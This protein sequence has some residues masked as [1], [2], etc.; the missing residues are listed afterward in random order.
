M[1]VTDEQ[2]APSAGARARLL[3]PEMRDRIAGARA[4]GE[5]TDDATDAEIKAYLHSTGVAC[6]VAQAR[7]LQQTLHPVAVVEESAPATLGQRLSTARRAAGLSRRDL[8][9]TVGVSESYLSYLE[10][11]RRDPS[12]STLAAIAVALGKES[13]WLLRGADSQATRRIA[14]LLTFV[15]YAIDRGDIPEAEQFLGQL[16]EEDLGRPL[17]RNERDQ[18]LVQ[19]ALRLRIQGKY[20]EMRECLAPMFRRCLSGDSD[21]SV[22]TVGLLY[23]NALMC[24]SEES[25]RLLADAVLV[26]QQAMAISERTE[27]WWRVAATVVGCQMDLGQVSLAVVQGESWLRE[28]RES[29]SADKFPSAEAALLWNLGNADEMVGRLDAALAKTERALTLQDPQEYPLDDARLKIQY[30]HHL[31]LARPH[32]VAEAIS[33]LEDCRSVVEKICVPEDLFEWTRERARAEM[34][35]GRIAQ[36]ENLLIPIL[37]RAGRE[38]VRLT[39]EMWLLLGDMRAWGGNPE[40][41]Y[42]AYSAATQMLQEMRPSRVTARLWR[43][44]GDRLARLGRDPLEVAGTYARALDDDDL[45]ARPG[46]PPQRTETMA[47]R[48]RLVDGT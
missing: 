5:L 10:S 7:S 15:R 44:T 40:P 39:V 19:Q 30:A 32:R 35:A 16:L 14:D 38:P 28:L 33:V 46:L 3:M 8:S 47:G 26:G 42:A 36:A 13:E 43:D 12:P 48:P 41:A 27:G 23:M 2:P 11:D 31:M 17:Y 1:R 45:P 20:Q 18:A 9:A 25:G 37:D 24:S 6:S 29:D 21:E 22:L 4:N 34:I